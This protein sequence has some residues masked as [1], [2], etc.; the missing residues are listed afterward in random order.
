M[1]FLQYMGCSKN[2]DPFPDITQHNIKR[3]I[4]KQYVLNLMLIILTYNFN[5]MSK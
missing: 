3:K 5:A 1:P 2:P 4:G